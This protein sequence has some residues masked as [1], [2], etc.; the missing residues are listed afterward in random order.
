MQQDP[1]P[2]ADTLQVPSSLNRPRP[3]DWPNLLTEWQQSGLTQKAFCRKKNIA[4]SHFTYYRTRIKRR[5]APQKKLLPIKVVSDP[6][7][8]FHQHPPITAN[9]LKYAITII[10]KNGIQLLVPENPETRTLV[11]LLNTLKNDS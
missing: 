1:H 8:S 10:F 9:K 4:L 7:K 6:K 5:L 11:L 3:T 2:Q